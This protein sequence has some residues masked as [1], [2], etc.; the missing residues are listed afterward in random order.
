MTRVT[1]LG[2]LAASIAHEVNQPL[3]AIVADADA[4][5]NWLAGTDP[6]LDNAREALAA[7]ANEGNR[8]A[9]VVQRIRQLAK[10]T[11]PRKTSID[12]NH[13]I[14]DV[15]LL[16][17]AELGRHHVTLT[18]DLASEL[19]LVLGDR[20]QLQQ[21]LLNLT[22]NAIDAMATVADRSRELVIR[23]SQSDR[24]HVMIAVQDT[25][26]GIAANN[27]DHV[28]SAFFTTK[29]SGMG[30]GLSIS[31]SIIESHGGRLWATP[32]PTHGA[33]FH[34]AVPVAALS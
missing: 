10:K 21:V 18:L 2:E 29:A 12:L 4:G 23:A 9:E 30:M 19:P 31:R 20:I 11:P 22:M 7:I 8:A 16:L 17:R 27:L 24:D 3:A 28:F 13:V 32:N 6:R 33:T 5:L 26:V 15:V 1:T 34:F 14:Q 25:G